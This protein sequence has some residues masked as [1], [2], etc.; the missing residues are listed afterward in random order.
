MGDLVLCCH[1]GQSFD[2]SR[3][4][5]ITVG[6]LPAPIQF[7]AIRGEHTDTYRIAADV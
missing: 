1:H 5:G 7:L 6:D 3:G 4:T 2:E